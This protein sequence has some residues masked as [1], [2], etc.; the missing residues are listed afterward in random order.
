[1]E[2]HRVLP[3]I[4]LVDSAASLA[5]LASVGVGAAPPLSW[6]DWR[7]KVSPEPFR[8]LHILMGSDLFCLFVFCLFFHDHFYNLEITLIFPDSRE[9]APSVAED[10]IS[11]LY[12]KNEQ[13]SQNKR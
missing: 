3:L 6:Q 10:L 13:F 4:D 12:K 7:P 9:R 8:L 5:A 1:L 11:N 2:L